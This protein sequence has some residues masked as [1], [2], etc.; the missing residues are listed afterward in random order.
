MV[1]S[2]FI[3][4]RQTERGVQGF[5]QA[6]LSGLEIQNVCVCGSLFG[7]LGDPDSGK[8]LV[9]GL[10]TQSATHTP[11]T[12]QESGTC[13]RAG[14]VQCLKDILWIGPNSV[15]FGGNQDTN[16]TLGVCHVIHDGFLDR[17]TGV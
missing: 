8:G 16:D 10:C 11:R 2:D 9:L 4:S 14:Q 17:V 5:L 7:S 13:A 6:T 15:C 3:I 1:V 12:L